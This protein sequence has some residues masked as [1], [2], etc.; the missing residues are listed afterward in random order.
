MISSRD[1]GRSRELIEV[2][3]A[4]KNCNEEGR[5][6]DEKGA[7][8]QSECGGRQSG[9]LCEQSSAADT[10]EITFQ[11]HSQPRHAHLI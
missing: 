2:N 10:K 7:G 6:L 1:W 3:K 5:A 4:A 9:D 8:E 11:Q